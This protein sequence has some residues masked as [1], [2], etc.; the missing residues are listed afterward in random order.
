MDQTSSRRLVLVIHRTFNYVFM[1]VITGFKCRTHVLPTVMWLIAN[2]LFVISQ[3][4]CNDMFH[5]LPQ[6]LGGFETEEDLL[7]TGDPRSRVA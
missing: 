5:N 4:K 3:I 7:L 2:K 1:F 6:F